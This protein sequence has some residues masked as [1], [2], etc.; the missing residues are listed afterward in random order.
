MLSG[1]VLGQAITTALAAY[2][3]GLSEAEKASQLVTWKLIAGAIVTHIQTLG[4]VNVITTGA[5]GTGTPGGPLPIVAQPGVGT[6][7]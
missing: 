2:Q 6:V 7:T 4:V 5:T 3:T 1:D